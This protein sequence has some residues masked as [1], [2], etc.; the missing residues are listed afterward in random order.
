[1]KNI[2]HKSNPWEGQ[3]CARGDCLV[4]AQG[5][6]G[7]GKCSKRNI[8]YKTTCLACKEKGKDTNYYGESARTAYE[9]GKEHRSD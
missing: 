7:A 4:C 1:M 2:L 3:L 5:G 8:L 9:R 6:D